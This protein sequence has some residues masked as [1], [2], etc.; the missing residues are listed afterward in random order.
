MEFDLESLLGGKKDIEFPE[1]WESDPSGRYIN[2]K[3]D[4]VVKLF[5][6]KGFERK[7]LALAALDIREGRSAYFVTSGSY[8]KELND[9]EI[10]IIQKIESYEQLEDEFSGDVP[11]GT[12]YVEERTIK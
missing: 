3:R 7:I 1:E 6:E 11:K 10:V 12:F 2:A 9:V 5:E 4:E 8:V